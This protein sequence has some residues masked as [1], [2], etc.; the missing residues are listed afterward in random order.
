MC[1]LSTQEYRA[2]S[3]GPLNRIPPHPCSPPEPPPL[4]SY[5]LW[6]LLPWGLAEHKS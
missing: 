2:E 5:P 3:K 1:F 6:H 4:P